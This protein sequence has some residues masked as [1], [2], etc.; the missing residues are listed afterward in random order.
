MHLIDHT[1]RE[2]MTSVVSKS[3][4][5]QPQ[6]QR[7]EHLFNHQRTIIGSHPLSGSHLD[8]DQNEP[9]DTEYTVPEQIA[10]PLHIRCVLQPDY[11]NLFSFQT[12]STSLFVTLL[13]FLDSYHGS[14]SEIP[15]SSEN[16]ETS[17]RNKFKEYYK[18]KVVKDTKQKVNVDLAC[19]TMLKLWRVLLHSIHIVVVPSL[20]QLNDHISYEQK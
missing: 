14:D 4:F 6:W 9:T 13:A 16:V 17:I 3:H 2:G 12:V 1:G 11:P 20:L 7:F 10:V 15:G 18:A 19:E 8:H 5:T